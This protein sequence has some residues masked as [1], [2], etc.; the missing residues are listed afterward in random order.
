MTEIEGD[1]GEYEFITKGMQLSKD[2]DGLCLEIGLRRG[3]GTK[4]IIDAITQVCP[5]KIAMAIDP[6]G[7]I[8]YEGRE[9]KPC[10]LDYTNTMMHEC[11]INMHQY[12]MDHGVHY[13]FFPL[14]DTEFFERFT[15]GVPVYQDFKR[16]ETK[17]SF[18][19]LDATHTVE[20]V[21]KQVLFFAERM[22]S[23]AVIC[24]DDVTIDFMDIVP[25][26]KVLVE[27]GFE[28]IQTGLK[29]ALYQKI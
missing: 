17:Y 12:A 7:S 21:T 16:M 10:R 5:S 1:S 19:H 29:K 26:E 3:L 15:D 13:L 25:I 11:Q 23:N 28:M 4:Y 20:A 9:G 2:A 8:I 6:Y 18:V 27:Q 24:I 14:E 22:D